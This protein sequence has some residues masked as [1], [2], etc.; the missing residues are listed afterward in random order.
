MI[1]S[2]NEKNCNKIMIVGNFNI[3][4][5]DFETNKKVEKNFN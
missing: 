4:V 5:L 3:N 1:S 2:K